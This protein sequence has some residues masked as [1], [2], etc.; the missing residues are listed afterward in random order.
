[1]AKNKAISVRVNEVLQRF[2]ATLRCVMRKIGEASFFYACYESVLPGRVA[3]NDLAL[4][5]QEVTR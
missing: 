3:W 2:V 1:M 5:V 4:N